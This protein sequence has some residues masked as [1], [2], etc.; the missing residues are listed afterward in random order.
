MNQ[1]IQMAPSQLTSPT[2]VTLRISRAAILFS[3]LARALRRAL[4]INLFPPR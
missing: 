1:H 4:R 3:P 2:I